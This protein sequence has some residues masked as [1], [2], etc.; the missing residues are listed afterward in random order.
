[1]VC[2]SDSYSLLCL[3]S[4]NFITSIGENDGRIPISITLMTLHSPHLHGF[5]D[6]DSTSIKS[7]LSGMKKAV[8]ATKWNKELDSKKEEPLFSRWSATDER[9]LSKLT[10]QSIVLTEQTTKMANNVLTLCHGRK[11]KI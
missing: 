10:S 6:P 5:S 8:M 1:M 2:S 3:F 7:S 4:C 9:N 11:E